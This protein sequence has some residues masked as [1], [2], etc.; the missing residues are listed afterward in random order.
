MPHLQVLNYR[1]NMCYTF[2]YHTHAASQQAL[3]RMGVEMMKKK[4]KIQFSELKKTFARR[5]N[6]PFEWARQICLRDDMDVGSRERRGFASD[7]RR[8]REQRVNEIQFK[9]E[10][11]SL[12]LSASAATS[13]PLEWKLAAIENNEVSEEEAKGSL[14]NR[15][16]SWDEMFYRHF[17]W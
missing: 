13:H 14:S 11:S 4:M 12:F 15:H 5:D 2:S 6:F 8:R 1:E 17:N 3:R 16:T 9:S 10:F 7:R